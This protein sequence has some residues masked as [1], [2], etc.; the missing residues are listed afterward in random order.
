M[1]NI[2]TIQDELK[3]IRNRNFDGMDDNDYID[4]IESFHNRIKD[5][6]VWK[7]LE[8]YDQFFAITILTDTFIAENKNER[9]KNQIDWY[10]WLCNQNM[11][12]QYLVVLYLIE[13]IPSVLEFFKYL[14]QNMDINNSSL[15]SVVL[16]HRYINLVTSN[17]DFPIKFDEDFKKDIDALLVALDSDGIFF[18]V[19]YS[20]LSNI[21]V[22]NSYTAYFRDIRY[23]F[24]DR[25]LEKYASNCIDIIR[26]DKWEKNKNALLARLI[27][28]MSLDDK[29][30]DLRESLWQEIRTFV[31]QEKFIQAKVGD[32]T[33]DSDLLLTIASFL[34]NA[35][36]C[37]D[38][39]KVVLFEGNVQ[40][41]GSVKYEVDYKAIER[42]CYLFAVAAFASQILYNQEKKELAD[43]LYTYLLD[44]FNNYIAY[45][46]PFGYDT[47][48]SF[49]AVYNAIDAV[50]FNMMFFDVSDDKIIESLDSIKDLDNKMMA[51][52]I[53]F[54]ETKKYKGDD[55]VS[56]KIK[57]F[58]KLLLPIIESWFSN[59]YAN[60]NILEWRQK[61]L[62]RIKEEV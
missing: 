2:L 34:A 20:L 54:I 50:W 31:T 4:Y 1:E 37:I 26:N 28:F 57:E 25:L 27:I 46:V 44:E 21:W 18:T 51:A 22:Y 14:S 53:Y 17:K 10:K 60:E 11:D 61:L 33:N 38:K 30:F 13:D 52:Y 48:H 49:S 6:S 59:E 39:L 43:K 55:A 40:S 35:D 29:P 8:N 58:I 5:F 62:N 36:D 41:Y 45:N 9:E 7:K 32:G 16:I 56:L 47:P 42:Q 24:I 19:F 12:I 23:A 15:V 3:L